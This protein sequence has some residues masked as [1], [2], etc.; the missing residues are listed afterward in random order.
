MKRIFFLLGIALLLVI[1]AANAQTYCETLGQ[2]T[3]TDRS[4]ESVT[5]TPQGDDA[6]IISTVLTSRS[7]GDCYRGVQNQGAAISVALGSTIQVRLNG[8][9]NWTYVNCFADWNSDGDFSDDGE[10][11]GKLPARESSFNTDDTGRDS[12]RNFSITIPNNA[13]IGETRLRLFMAWGITDACTLSSTTNA[14]IAADFLLNITA[15]TLANPRTVSVESANASQGTAVISNTTSTS[16]TTTDGVVSVTANPNSGYKFLN[17][18]NKSTSAIVSTSNPYLYTGSSDITLVANF[19]EGTY[20]EMK[21]YFTNNSNQQNRYFAQATTTGTQTPIVFE[22]TSTS[23][24]PY[25]ALPAGYSANTRITSGAL[26]DK[27]SNPIIVESGTTSFTLTLKGYT[28]A[29]DGNS[30]EISWT[31][32]AC[33]IDWDRNFEFS[34]ANEISSKT[35]DNGQDTSFDTGHTR[36]ITIPNGQ[37]PGTYRMRI[38]NFEPSPSTENWQNTLFTTKNAE[39]RNGVAYDFAIQILDPAPMQVAAVSVEA[40]EGEANLGEKNV[41]IGKLLV[42]TTGNLDPISLTALTANLLGNTRNITNVRLIHSTSASIAGKTQVATAS[43]ASQMQFEGTKILNSGNNYFWIVADIANDATAGQ[44]IDTEITSVS[45]GGT[46]FIPSPINGNGVVIISNIIDY[47]KGLSIWFS[48]PN[49]SSRGAAW[50]S[51]NGD[52][53]SNPDQEWEKKSLPIG[54]GEF[55]GNVLGSISRER[56]TLN[57]K[58]LWKGGPATGASNYWNMNKN[59][60]S[61]LPSIQQ[62]LTSGNV[63]TAASQVQN[64]YNG[65]IAYDSNVFGSFTTMG[66]AYINTGINEANVSE[67]KRILNIDSSLVVV[68]FKSG[69]VTYQR[70]FFCSY[71]DSVM[72]CRFTSKDGVQNMTFSFNCPQVVSSKGLDGENG[73]LYNCKLSNN[74]QQYVLRVYARSKDGSI[75]YN[76]DGTISVSNSTDVEFILAADTDYKVNFSPNTSDAYAYVGVDPLATTRSSIQNAKSKTYNELYNRHRNDYSSLFHRVEI[77]INPNRSFSDNDTPTRLASYQGGTLDNRLEELYYQFGRYLLISSSRKGGMPANLQGVWHNNIEGPWRVDYHNNINVQMNYWPAAMTNLLDCYDPLITYIKSLIEPG[78][79]TSQAYYGV[80]DGWTAAISGNIYGFTAPLNSA[81]MTWNY[82]PSAG[83]WLA[84]HL[85]EYYDYSRDIDWLRNVGYDMIKGSAQ[86]VIGT[87]YEYNGELN[88]TPSWSPEHGSIDIGTTY[89]HAVAKEV[90][91][92]AIKSAQLLNTDNDLIATWQNAYNKIRPYQIGQ[93]G[94]LQEWYNDID[95]PTDDHR[96]TNHLFGLHPGTTISPITTPEL[97]EACKKTLTQRG[98]LATG[99]S[100]GWKLNHWA[101]LHD[102][103]HAYTLYQNLLKTGTAQNLWDMHPPFQIDG[104]F[105]GTAGIT[106]M[107]MQSHLGFIHLLPALPDDWQEGHLTGILAKGAFEVDVHWENNELSYADIL[108]N[109]GEPCIIRYKNQTL[110]FDTEPGVAYTVVFDGTNLQLDDRVGVL[111]AQIDKN[112]GILIYPNPNNGHFNVV[113]GSDFNER[114]K[115][116]I[117][118][119]EGKVLKTYET[120]KTSENQN[121]SLQLEQP[122]GAYILKVQDKNKIDSQVI[123][124][125]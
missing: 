100:M 17:W 45:I 85:W 58:T 55:G 43:S 94:Q 109:K 48:S 18:K 22:A 91:I 108:S 67:Y 47:T 51:N 93:Y 117:M 50:N 8:Y 122:T 79:R 124:V 66:E 12:Y 114:V 29:I 62:N 28:A 99:W 60:A 87:L 37:L 6:V 125:K 68:Q 95:S 72:V 78:Q 106:E 11:I 89:A 73:M 69:G 7:N 116:S 97:A 81:E 101:R 16:I 74:N 25:T 36:T 61:L 105:G 64:N 53:A 90:L 107:I 63:S 56:I 75:V 57:E 27:T 15:T 110:N 115:I 5:I 120:N 98:D 32:Q 10:T 3:K 111:S 41:P 71:T 42:Q 23:Q 80:A 65:T 26:I 38:V 34:G 92:A 30:S 113:L 52:T 59:S 1:S 44:S 49:S 9:I 35:S 70:K 4:W 24:L 54:N 104:N 103:N 39:I 82:N 76:S 40:L 13:S 112:K 84:T 46:Q 20:P 31:Q 21:R 19:A 102:G 118:S 2:S 88:A 33:F 119:S 86:F 77:S 121:I 14:A 96:H 83:P 123:F